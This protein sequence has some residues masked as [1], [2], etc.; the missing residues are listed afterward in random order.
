MLRVLD[1]RKVI[2]DLAK[3]GFQETALEHFRSA[4]STTQGLVILTGPTGSGKSSTLYACLNRLNAPEV[5]IVTVEDPVEFDIDGINQV[6]VKEDVGLTFAAAL[7][8]FLR[9]DPNIVLVGEI[10]DVATAKTAMQASMTGHLVLS[11]LHT[12][13]APQAVTRMLDIGITPDNRP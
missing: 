1:D 9:Q 6:Q 2:T 4:I 12:N 5:N 7:K 10:R 3:I 8:A 11:T 13:D